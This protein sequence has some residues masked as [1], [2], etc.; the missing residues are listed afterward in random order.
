ML[1]VLSRDCF[2]FCC[3]VVAVVVEAG[4]WFFFLGVVLSAISW[5]S[6]GEV[7]DGCGLSR[8]TFILSIS[9]S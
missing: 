1:S 3:R 4:G 6:V 5:G 8:A 7:E 2:C 9:E